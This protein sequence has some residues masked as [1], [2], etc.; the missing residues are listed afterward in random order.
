MQETSSPAAAAQEHFV[1]SPPLS[2]PWTVPAH[3]GGPPPSTAVQQSSSVQTLCSS[4]ILRRWRSSLK[5]D[6]GRSLDVD[7]E[8]INRLHVCPWWILQRT[9]RRSSRVAPATNPSGGSQVRV[10]V[11]H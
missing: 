3:A 1:V 2:E 5:R 10:R 7:L 9:T 8:A 11:F 4:S 6:P